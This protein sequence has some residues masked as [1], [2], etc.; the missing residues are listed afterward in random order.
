MNLH[1]EVEAP[2]QGTFIPNIP[3]DTIQR[4]TDSPQAR[5]D[6]IQHPRSSNGSDWLRM[7]ST[8]LAFGA[9][10]RDVSVS[11]V[12]IDYEVNRHVLKQRTFWRPEV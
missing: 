1:I 8:A 7:Q 4:V 5:H 9:F 2:Q 3:Q 6:V 11:E 10:R 12:D